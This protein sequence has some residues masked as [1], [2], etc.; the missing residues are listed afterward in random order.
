MEGVLQPLLLAKH[1]PNGLVHI[2]LS[3]TSKHGKC[4]H[5]F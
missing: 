2:F 4:I 1:S 5:L 3:T